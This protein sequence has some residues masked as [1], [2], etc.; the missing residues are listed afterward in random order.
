MLPMESGQFSIL[1]HT[2][3]RDEAGRFS[4]TDLHK[5][6]GGEKRNQPSDWLRMQQTQAFI[7]LLES[8][9]PVP[10]IPGTEKINDL[11]PVNVVKGF[12]G[13]QGTYV[14]K[15]LVYDYAMWVSPEFKWLVIET[16][17]A[18]ANGRLHE[19]EELCRNALAGREAVR[20]L[21]ERETKK[22]KTYA[23]DLEQ[24]VVY[25]H[26]W[27]AVNEIKP[28]STL[29]PEVATQLGITTYG[30]NGN[31]PRSKH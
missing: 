28:N 30:L 31:S 15:H 1:S 18:V 3:R 24:E 5:A 22:W 12:D 21:G 26:D 11:A 10:G 7:E 17:D 16:F 13:D 25:L 14:C 27:M 9:V 19:A 6:A 23:A 4:L 8:K 29:D 20:G 2:I